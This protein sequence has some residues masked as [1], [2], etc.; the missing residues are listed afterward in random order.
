M[1]SLSAFSTNRMLRTIAASAALLL[2][3][4]ASA[5]DEQFDRYEVRV[6][7]PKYFTKASRLETGAQMSVIMNQS[8]IYTYLATG[9]LDYHLSE[10]FALEGVFAY[11]YS[12]DK[13]DKKSLDSNFKIKTQILRTQHFMEGGVL[14]TPVYGKYQLSSGRVVYLDTFFS[15]GAGMTG[16]SYLYDHCPKPGDSTDP[17]ITINE[18][19]AATTKSYPTFYMGGGQRIFLDK[20]TSFRWDVRGH[21]FSYNTAD[22]ACDASN[23][24][25]EQKGQTNITMQLGAGYFL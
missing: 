16:V 6:I 15:A 10:M 25:K 12:I 5:V 13:D 1:N 7:R 8:F 3:V 9:L 4:P 11:G 21:Y 23:A 19:P 20:K 18:P 17:K 2:A 22:G 14:Y 24:T